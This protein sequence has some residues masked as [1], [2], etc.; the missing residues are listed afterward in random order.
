MQNVLSEFTLQSAPRVGIIY[1]KLRYGISI[2]DVAST[3]ER[4]ET[5]FY[6]ENNM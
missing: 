4:A 5:Y 3:T 2:V 1:D 6:G